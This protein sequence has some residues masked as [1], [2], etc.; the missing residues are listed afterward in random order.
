MSFASSRIETA[1]PISST[2]TSPPEDSDP[3]RI[4]SCTASGIVMKNRVIA[5]SV[6]VTGPPAAIWRRKIGTTEP[7]D[8][9]TLPKRTLA[10]CVSGKR[11]SP[12][13]TAHSASALDAP[14][15]VAG[16]TALSV[17]TSTNTLTPKTVM[18][19]SKALAEWAVEA[20][21]AHHPRTRYTTVRF[22]NVLGSS[23]SVVQIFRAQIA[24]G[25][26]VTVTDDRM[27][28]Y[29]MTIP[30]AVQLIIRA[31]SL[32]EG[33]EIFVLEM[34]EPVPIADLARDM[35]RLSGLEPDEDIAIEIVGRRPGE[36]L[37]EDLFNPYERPQETPAEKI[38]AAERPALDPSWVE[39]T[40]GQVNVLVLEGDAAGLATKVAELS[41]ARTAPALRV[42]S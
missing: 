42:S 33:G 4:T 39:E 30:E 22:G 1:S 7:E 36:K 28:R 25:G 26:P 21:G 29:F 23:G 24:A 11:A 12:A 14:M 27:T 13:S 10:N 5:G 9:S 34:G 18:G 35:I 8:P 3:E 20:A 41:T 32:G 40:F 16:A 6:T 19:A 37:H 31:G 15:T 38:L 2:N 17:D